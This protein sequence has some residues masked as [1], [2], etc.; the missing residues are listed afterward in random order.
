MRDVRLLAILVA[1]TL[2]SIG[3]AA[4]SEI[5]RAGSGVWLEIKVE[6]ASNVVLTDSNGR[7]SGRSDT[8]HAA[9]PGCKYWEGEL[10]LE[11]RHSNGPVVNFDLEAP[12]RGTYRLTGSAAEQNV[13]ISCVGSDEGKNTALFDA[14]TAREGSGCAWS[15]EWAPRGPKD[16]PEVGLE[17]IQLPDAGGRQELP[18]PAFG[19][20]LVV[21]DG[22]V[23][24]TMIDRHGRRTGWDG[25]PER[26]A[27][28]E[29][30]G[31][32]YEAG[33][34]GEEGPSQVPAEASHHLRHAQ[35]AGKGVPVRPPDVHAFDFGEAEGAGGGLFADGTCEL[36]IVAPRRLVAG[37]G[38]RT[39]RGPDMNCYDRKDD[40]LQAGVL[41]RCRLKWSTSVDSC[42]A[43]IADWKIE[44]LERHRRR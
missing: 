21:V 19:R 11:G 36:Q 23:W 14:V 32:R 10:S 5:S 1:W 9:I 30:R 12:A 16:A 3:V 43:R 38:I 35:S 6:G 18:K 25:G 40:T 44:P 8:S 2:A 26:N 28:R 4:T 42:V 20:V 39:M 31:C 33:D 41:Y 34:E 37:V 13:S 22:G 17:R 27:R 29:I 7:R 15:I 24:A